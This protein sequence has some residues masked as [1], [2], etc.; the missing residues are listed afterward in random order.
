M[1]RLKLKIDPVVLQAF[2]TRVKTGIRGMGFVRTKAD[3][4]WPADLQANV[5]SRRRRSRATALR[6][7]LRAPQIAAPAAPSPDSQTPVAK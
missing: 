5:Q 1:F 2:Y 4:A 3:V 6:R 7:P